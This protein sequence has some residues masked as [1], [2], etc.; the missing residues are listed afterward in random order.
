MPAFVPGQRLGHIELE[1]LLGKGGMGEVWKA[2]DHT[3]QRTV[4]VKTLATKLE[5]A[6]AR[7]LFVREA[8]AV[9]ALGHPHIATIFDVGEHEG[10]VYFVMEYLDGTSLRQV[11]SRDGRLGL[12][13]WFEVALAMA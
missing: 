1:S 12:R 8:Q 2:Q 7:Q 4:A 13:R 11:L 10:T 6:A 5:S 9:A 3:L